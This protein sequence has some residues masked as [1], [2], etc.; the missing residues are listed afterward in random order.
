MDLCSFP[1]DFDGIGG[2][3]ASPARSS[4]WCCIAGGLLFSVILWFSMIVHQNEPNLLLTQGTT[5]RTGILTL[6]EFWWV[7]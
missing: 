1:M 2:F 7:P 3:G 5:I 6:I 4:V